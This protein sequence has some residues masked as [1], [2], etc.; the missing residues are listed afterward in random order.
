MPYSTCD[1]SAEKAD[2]AKQVAD[3]KAKWASPRYEGITRSYSAEE[4]AAK[5]GSA[6]GRQV[7]LANKLSEKLF[8]LLTE[9]EKV[10]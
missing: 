3:L 9:H 10:S 4:V 1:V 7:P 2:F 8:N 5:T 6:L